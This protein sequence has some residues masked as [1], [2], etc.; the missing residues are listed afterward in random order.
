MSTSRPAKP[1]P[2]PKATCGNCHF[3]D[4]YGWCQRKNYFTTPPAPP[5]GEYR[6]E[7]LDHTNATAAIRPD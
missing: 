2:R 7:N 3:F 4:G 1:V 5:C 6:R